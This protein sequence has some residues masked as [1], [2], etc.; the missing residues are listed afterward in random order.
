[1]ISGAAVISHAMH[2]M[3]HV[4]AVRGDMVS[5]AAVISYTHVH[6]VTFHT[7]A[8][9]DDLRGRGDILHLVSRH[10]IEKVTYPWIR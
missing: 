6:D 10:A 7:W 5:E 4:T 9:R 1:M 2:M 3:L 8:L